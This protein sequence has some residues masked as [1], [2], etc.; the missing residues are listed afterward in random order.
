[1][2][3]SDLKIP[4]GS[5]NPEEEGDSFDWR[6]VLATAR[7]KL[8]LLILLPV[9][10]GAIGWAYL[11]KTPSVYEARATLEVENKQK[12]VKFEDVTTGSL[13]SQEAMNT[14]SATIT[15]RSL[16]EFVAERDRL[17]ERPELLPAGTKDRTP[18]RAAGV[19]G[20]MVRAVVR[21]ETRLMDIF[22]RSENP[23]LA[24]DVAEAVA[25]GVI[26]YGIE[27]K[28]RA[29]GF[30]TEFLMQE[31]ERL[32]KKL[33]S[34]E[35][36]LQKYRDD[37]NAISLEDNQNLVVDQLKD[38]NTQFSSASSSR[39]QLE[40]DFAAIDAMKDLSPESL[41]Q[42]KSVATLP[43][44][45]GVSQR[46]AAKESEFIILK[47]RYKQKHPKY[48]AMATEIENLQ[49]QLRS[50]LAD[51]KKL[52]QATYEAAKVN[53]EKF[54]SALS[55]NEQKAMDL[56]RIAIQYNV[57]KREMETDKTMYNSVLARLKEVDLTKGLEQNELSIHDLPQL[58]GGPVW[59][60]LSKVMAGSVGGGFMLGLGIILLIH[61]MDRTIKTVD[62]AE[63]T[64]GLAV[65]AAVGRSKDLEKDVQ[66][67][68]KEPH[69]AV[70]ESF[71][72]LRVMAT[73]LGPEAERR[74]FLL[75]SALPSE[76]KTFCSANFAI[77][78][79]QQ[80]LRTLIIDADLRRPRVSS[81]FFNENRKPGL[82]ELLVGKNPLQEVCHRAET[83]NLYVIPAG[84]KS[85]NPA[86][87]LAG[88]QFP[89]VIEQALKHFDRVIIDTAPV[90][91]VSDTLLL[92]PYVQT[93]ILVVKW[94]ATPKQVIQRAVGMLRGAGKGP[95]GVVL[96]QMPTKSGSYYYYYSPGYYGS[97]G[98]YGA[99]A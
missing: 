72:S 56:N 13:H 54:R 33:E 62:Q 70:A 11:Q 39:V 3:L 20:G 86:E 69:G 28:A 8:W 32:K 74:V 7:T 57:L 93:V 64:L 46:I 76:G 51:S 61:F 40:T 38:M 77:S 98:V 2:Q 84:E 99:P 87:L 59:P 90:I 63:K 71:R 42:L 5:H 81:A 68:V 15:S 45:Q 94:S 14:V 34:S 17:Y 65:M 91:A 75:T 67:I 36:A 19:L 23:R 44:V 58:P 55:T 85:P 53:E 6:G 60:S 35:Q 92:V 37:N 30:A 96:N 83:E 88:K 22:V 47:Q 52:L 25:A 41:L 12:V 49:K 21:K 50:T 4:A 73:L 80:G 10:G 95:S 48:I 97:K 43:A 24:R 16:L 18:A 1:M 26:R 31:A 79:A 78:L 89:L 66:E 82:T 29:A 27:Q 9:I